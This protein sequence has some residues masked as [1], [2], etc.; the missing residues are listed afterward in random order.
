MEAEYSYVNIQYSYLEYSVLLYSKYYSNFVSNIHVPTLIE[1][2]YSTLNIHI[3][4]ISETCYD[5][6]SYS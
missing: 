6:C 2:L 5:L 3:P 1:Y 4:K